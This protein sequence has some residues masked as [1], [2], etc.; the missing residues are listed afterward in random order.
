MSENSFTKVTKSLGRG[1][2]STGGAMCIH[3]H[4]TGEVLTCDHKSN[5]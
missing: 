3:G 4:V 5:L 2:G 1:Y